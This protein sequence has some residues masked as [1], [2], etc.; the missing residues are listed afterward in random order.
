MLKKL[1]IAASVSFAD[2][3]TGDFSYKITDSF[4]LDFNSSYVSFDAYSLYSVYNRVGVN[5]DSSP[6]KANTET[7]W[8]TLASIMFFSP[9]ISLPVSIVYHHCSSLSFGYDIAMSIRYLGLKL[10]DSDQD[11]VKD[12][13]TDTDKDT[14]SK[15]QLA[16]YVKKETNVNGR[17]NFNWLPIASFFVEYNFGMVSGKYHLGQALYAYNIYSL[18][19]EGAR[20]FSYGEYFFAFLH[21]FELKLNMCHGWIASMV[22]NSAYRSLL[23]YV[24]WSAEKKAPATVIV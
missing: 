2:V 10:T 14:N 18:K 13:L 7:D 3:A 16:A 17:S 9:S 8:S 4:S 6:I 22:L 11:I 5:S 23:T 21:G 15:N 12:S 19:V 1:F 24:I 20:M